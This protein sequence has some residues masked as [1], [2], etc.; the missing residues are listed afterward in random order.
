MRETC[1][2][3]PLR[4]L[5][6]DGHELFREGLWRLLSK[7]QPARGGARRELSVVG[8]AH[9]GEEAVTL[10]RKEGPNLALTEVPEP[11]GYAQRYLRRLLG[12]C[13]PTPKI[14]V[15]TA[16]EDPRLGP[17]L[18]AAGASAFLH[19]SATA[20]ELLSAIHASGV[21]FGPAADAVENAAE[22][23]LTEREREVIL[24][25]ARG[26]ANGQIARTLCLSEATV[27]RHLA[28]AYRKAGAR[29]RTEAARKAL[30]E[31]WISVE[32]V[33]RG[34]ASANT[35]P[36]GRWGRAGGGA[37]PPQDFRRRGS[38]LGSRP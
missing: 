3:A 14:V 1:S 9:H 5:L 37:V 16:L 24:L 32:E 6:A 22:P 31:G 10:A 19:K 28:N 20:G 30:A 33:T 27:K 25:A 34:S 11:A 18:L 13:S 21:A 4:V 23:P 7:G 17:E 36:G 8:R 15:V 29:S 38:G 35:P 12:A 2:S 26:L